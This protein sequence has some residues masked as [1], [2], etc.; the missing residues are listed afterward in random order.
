MERPGKISRLSRFSLSIIT[1]GHGNGTWHYQVGD[2]GRNFIYPRSRANIHKT[3]PYLKGSPL[4]L[5][6]V[7]LLNQVCVQRLRP[8]IQVSFKS[9]AITRLRH[10]YSFTPSSTMKTVYAFAVAA[11]VVA[12]AQNLADLPQCAVSSFPEE[13]FLAEQMS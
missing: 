13:R 4:P 6:I 12:N 2:G 5:A 1:S 10:R 7:S 9:S 3:T 11:A 8:R